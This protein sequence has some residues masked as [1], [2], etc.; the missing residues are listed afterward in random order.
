MEGGG[1]EE[2]EGVTEK[3][4]QVS[5]HGNEKILVSSPLR[6]GRQM[7]RQLFQ[8]FIFQN[9]TSPPDQLGHEKQQILIVEAVEGLAKFFAHAHDLWREFLVTMAT[10]T[11]EDLHSN[12]SISTTGTH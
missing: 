9:L 5:S 1:E 2:G 3:G 8:I 6:P 4:K 11:M 10:V 12:D 7:P